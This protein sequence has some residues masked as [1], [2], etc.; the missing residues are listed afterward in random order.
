[1]TDAKHE[2]ACGASRSD[3]VLGGWIKKDREWS[4]YP[5][6]TKARESWKGWWWQKT[7]HGWKANGGS[8]FPRP[9]CADQVMLPLSARLV[10]RVTPNVK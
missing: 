7:D 10:E 9:G 5:I 6:G 2:G 1:M 4:E 3:A 8:T